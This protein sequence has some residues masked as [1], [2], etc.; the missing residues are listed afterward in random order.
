MKR[1]RNKFF[2]FGKFLVMVAV[3]IIIQNGVVVVQDAAPGTGAHTE[4]E[5]SPC[6]DLPPTDGRY[7]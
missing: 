2:D 6:S 4:E 7:T 5:A 3:V 1:F